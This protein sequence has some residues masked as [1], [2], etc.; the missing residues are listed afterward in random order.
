MPLAGD[1][2]TPR[3][4]GRSLPHW[5]RGGRLGALTAAK[6]RT[7]IGALGAPDAKGCVIHR[8]RQGNTI[9]SPCCGGTG[10]QGW[11]VVAAPFPAR[12]PLLERHWWKVRCTRNIHASSENPVARSAARAG[13]CSQ[14]GAVVGCAARPPLLLARHWVRGAG[15]PKGAPRGGRLELFTALTR[16]AGQRPA[17]ILLDLWAPRFIQHHRLG[18]GSTHS[19][20]ASGR[21]QRAA[22]AITRDRPRSRRRRRRRCDGGQR[23]A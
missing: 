18:R 4:G 14:G 6:R 9:Q 17:L 8:L 22:P 21:Q 23:L 15:H 20:G 12:R 3:A 10:W 2:Q 11:D 16:R 7:A 13:D 1:G 5:G 19:A